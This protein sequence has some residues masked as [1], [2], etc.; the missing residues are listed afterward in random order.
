MHGHS[1]IPVCDSA[2]G[3]VLVSISSVPYKQK[4]KIE[5]W[6]NEQIFDWFIDRNEYTYSEILKGINKELSTIQTLSLYVPEY[7]ELL[8]ISTKLLKDK[9]PIEDYPELYI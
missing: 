8:E 7:K 1:L 5:T 3:N 6:L 2:I 4:K 9:V